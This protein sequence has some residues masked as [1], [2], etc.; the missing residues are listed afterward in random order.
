MEKKEKLLIIDRHPFGTLV[1]TVKWC[2]YGRHIYD[3]TL[4]C[5]DDSKRKSMDG[6]DIVRIAYDGSII[7]RGIRY[8]YNAFKILRR[9]KGHIF[10]VYFEGCSILKMFFP[11][12][13][14]H[15]DVRTLSVSK[16]SEVRRKYDKR[17]IKECAKFD[18][19]STLSEGIRSKMGLKSVKL[20]PLGADIISPSE[21]SYG[22]SIRLLYVGTL[23]NRHISSTIYGLKIFR[24]KHPDVIVKYDIIGDGMQSEN[25]QLLTAI[26]ETDCA[27]IVKWHGRIEF[28]KLRKYFDQANV[29]VSFVPITDYYKYQPPTK[30]YEYVRSGLFCI[31]THTLENAKILT[32]EVGALI[33]DSEDGFVIGLETFLKLQDSLDFKIISSHLDDYSW[34][35]IVKTY[36]VDIINSMS[37][38]S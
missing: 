36:F 32:P 22:D 24:K 5:F 31:A 20:L 8:I 3:I 21:K 9:F 7:K 12:K 18:S 25:E 28:D 26:R 38:L 6:I 30:T 19:V 2:E 23:N 37:G 11:N 15:V 10:V 13:K 14:I 16:N 35:S 17:L 27:D 29:G 33:D 4:L 34:E 1:D